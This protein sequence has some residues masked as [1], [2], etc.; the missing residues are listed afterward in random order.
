MHYPRCN[1]LP[2]RT[3]SC[4]L[5]QRH[6]RDVAQ[7][8]GRITDITLSRMT[9]APAAVFCPWI[10]TRSRQRRSKRPKRS[11][12]LGPYIPYG[13]FQTKGEMSTK[14]RFDGFRNVNMCK[15]QTN[16]QTHTHTN[17]QKRTKKLSALYI[18]YLCNLAK[19]WLQAP[20]GQH[21]SVETCRSVI[22]CEIIVHLL[23]QVKNNKRCKVQVIK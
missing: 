16:K 17:K 23:V 12:N 5:L 20:W 11:R 4:R 9:L 6:F 18:R 22:I 19:Y 7:A 21:D 15:I 10:G 8:P 3:F 14:F 1:T 2:V 13:L